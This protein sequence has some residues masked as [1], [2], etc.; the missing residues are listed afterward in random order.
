[1]SQFT[2]FMSQMQNTF[3]GN[4]NQI[5]SR[6]FDSLSIHEPTNL[7][8]HILTTDV[9]NCSLRWSRQQLPVLLPTGL[10]LQLFIILPKLD[11]FRLPLDHGRCDA[12]SCWVSHRPSR[13]LTAVD[14]RPLLYFSLPPCESHILSGF[15]SRPANEIDILLSFLTPVPPAPLLEV[16]RR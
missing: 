8:L 13:F 6:K 12:R 5:A 16:C 11:S 15:P 7:M 1:M 2:S 14:S 3:G 4:F 10:Q 9:H